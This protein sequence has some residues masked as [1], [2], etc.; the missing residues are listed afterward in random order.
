MASYSLIFCF[1]V[2]LIVPLYDCFYS[3]YVDIHTSSAEFKTMIIKN[4]FNYHDIVKKS[5]EQD[6]PSLRSSKSRKRQQS[7]SKG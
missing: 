1:D 6:L 5:I 2:E 4:N 7:K 3:K